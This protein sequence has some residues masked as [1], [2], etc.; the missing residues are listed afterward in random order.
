MKTTR[1]AGQP[2]K[3]W[4]DDGR[5]LRLARD[6]E[7]LAAHHYLTVDEGGGFGDYPPRTYTFRE[8]G[9]VVR[10]VSNGSASTYAVTEVDVPTSRIIPD[11]G[12]AVCGGAP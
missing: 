8:A 12:M 7:T 4:T 11:N 5:F 6:G 1:I 3:L 2:A 10:R 9:T